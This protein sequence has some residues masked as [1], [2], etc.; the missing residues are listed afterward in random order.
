M[1]SFNEKKL[2]INEAISIEHP[3]ILNFGLSQIDRYGMSLEI[4]DIMIRDYVVSMRYPENI[5]DIKNGKRRLRSKAKNFL[6][7]DSALYYQVHH[8]KL[9]STKGRHLS[10]RKVL[11][12]EEEKKTCMTELHASLSGG[13]HLGREKTLHKVI[14]EYVN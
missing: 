8:R 13:G 11:F 3:K 6:W 9:D 14:I 12:T 1:H 10:K 2:V 5:K 7:E 4:N